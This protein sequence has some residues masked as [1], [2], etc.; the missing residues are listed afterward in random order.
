MPQQNSYDAVVVGAGPN[1]LT[2]AIVLARAGLSVLLLEAEETVGGGTRSAELTLPGYIHDVSSA[3]FPLA[4]ASPFLRT[5]DLTEHGLEWVHPPAALAHPFDDGTAALLS[6]SIAETGETLGRDA[7]AY[8]RLMRPLAGDW[9]RLMDDLLSPLRFPRHPIMLARFGLRAVRSVRGLAE[10]AFG[11]ER[12]RALLAG[13]AAHSTLPLEQGPT[14]A[15]GLVLGIAGHTVGWPLVRGGSQRFA[16]AMASYLRSL[17][18]E[19]ATG[20]QVESIDALPQAHIVLL[21]L[22]P[23]QIVRIAGH[24][25]PSRYRRRLEGFRYGPGAFKVDWALDGPVPWKASECARAGTVHLGGTLAEICEAERVVWRGE[26]PEKPFIV[27]A[28]QSLFDR[29]RAPDG[30]HTA[31]AYCHTPGGSTFDMTERVESQIERFA[32]GFRD[33][34]LARSTMTPVELER[35]NPNNVEGSI[36]GGV[37]DF[38]QLFARPVLRLEPYSTPLAGVYICSSSTP[39]GGGVHGMCGYLAARA[40]MRRS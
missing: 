15:F 13:M 18:G 1:G 24:R 19:I 22:T 9:E 6:R 5:L 21:D 12:G 26:H 10:S 7:D 4:A 28:Q 40:A 37:H 16:D 35:Y 30:K 31:W 32:P 3:M 25:L 38:R 33:R 2:A 17:G 11:T 23:R 39:P 36:T 20:T 8:Q 34:V 29:T 27:V 14:A